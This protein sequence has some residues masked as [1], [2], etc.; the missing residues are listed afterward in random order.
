V[1]WASPAAV[2]GVQDEAAGHVGTD[3]SGWADGVYE[4]GSDIGAAE[5][6]SR[7]IGLTLAGGKRILAALQ[8][9]LVQGTDG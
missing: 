2:P 3:R 5:Y 7:M 4:I 8:L 6:L 9:H 1:L